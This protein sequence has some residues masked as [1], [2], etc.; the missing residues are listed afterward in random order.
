MRCASRV[1]HRSVR[2]VEIIGEGGPDRVYPRGRENPYGYVSY[3]T[4][5]GSC[6]QN[7]EIEDGGSSLLFRVQSSKIFT[8]G[9]LCDKISK[10]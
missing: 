1:T 3:R 10:D 8:F 4:A 7:R 5:G 6:V 9:G 2:S